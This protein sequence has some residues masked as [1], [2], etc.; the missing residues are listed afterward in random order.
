MYIYSVTF[1]YSFICRRVNLRCLEMHYLRFIFL[2][3]LSD[4]VPDICSSKEKR[5]SLNNTYLSHR[6]M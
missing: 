1:L 5:F 4:P 6:L 2:W 3:F